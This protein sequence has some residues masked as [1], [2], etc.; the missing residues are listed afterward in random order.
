MSNFSQDVKTVYRVVLTFDKS[1][2][3]LALPHFRGYQA[4]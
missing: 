1:A 2:Q 4:N 3:L